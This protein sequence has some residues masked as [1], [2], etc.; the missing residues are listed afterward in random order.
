LLGLRAD[1][2]NPANGKLV[3]QSLTALAPEQAIRCNCPES[4][5]WD[6]GLQPTSGLRTARL[7]TVI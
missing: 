1:D 3:R 5:E 4:G 6:P 2:L 7:A